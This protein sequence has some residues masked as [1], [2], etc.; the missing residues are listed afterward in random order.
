MA[1]KSVRILAKHG[2]KDNVATTTV[3]PNEIAITSDTHELY[4][5]DELGKLQ[6]VNAGSTDALMDVLVNGMS[7]VQD[8]VATIVIDTGVSDAKD[9]NFNNTFT[10]LDAFNVQDAIDQLSVTAGTPGATG[11][12][13]PVGATGLLGATGPEGATGPI[14]A[15]GLT[16]ASGGTGARGDDGAGI[17]ITGSVDTWSELPSNLT[18]G[19]AGKSFLVRQDGLLYIWDGTQFPNN[20]F[21]IEFRGPRGDAGPQGDL[22]ATG[23]TGPQGNPGPIGATGLDGPMGATGPQGPVG[24]TG[25]QGVQGE[26]G[27][28]SNINPRGFWSAGTNNYVFN[29]YVIHGDQ[30]WIYMSSTPNQIGEPGISPIWGLFVIQGPIG[31]TGPQ[32]NTGGTGPQG[33][34]GSSGLSGPVGASGSQGLQGSV[35]AT[36]TQGPTGPQGERGATGPM[37]QQGATGPAGASGA[38]G[39]DGNSFIILGAYDNETLMR[40]AHPTGMAGDAWA[41]GYAGTTRDIFIWDISANDW[42]DIGNLEGP[43]GASGPQGMQG[44]IGPE[45]PDGPQGIQGATGPEGPAGSAGQQGPAGAPGPMGP[46]GPP[47]EFRLR[48]DWDPEVDD[49]QKQDYVTHLD[50]NAQPGDVAL[51]GWLY[52]NDTMGIIAEPGTNL[53]VWWPFILAGAQGPTGPQGLPGPEGERGPVGPPGQQGQQGPYGP[54]GSTGPAGEAIAV[55]GSFPTYMQMIAT[56]GIPGRAY[57]AEDTGMLY[58][59]RSTGGWPPANAGAF[60]QGQPGPPGPRGNTGLTGDMGAT[61]PQGDRG[62]QGPAGPLGP[63]GERGPEGPRGLEGRSFTIRGRHNSYSELISELPVGEEGWAYSIGMGVGNVDHIFLWDVDDLQWVD[64]GALEGP[65]GASGVPG[66]SGTPGTNGLTGGTGGVGAT[67]PQGQRGADGE[68]GATGPVGERGPMGPP[69]GIGNYITQSFTWASGITAT[70]IREGNWV[71]MGVSSQNISWGTMNALPLGYRPALP[72]FTL[73][74]QSQ[75]SSYRSIVINTNGTTTA[76]GAGT[77]TVTFGM[78]W[79]TLDPFP[80]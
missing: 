57:Y 36:G 51:K 60:I 72:A 78:V 17:S 48:F 46:I 31:A 1:T 74:G 42:V 61:G 8:G 26:V 27:P 64:I 44:N 6:K 76:G 43:T 70:L 45:G 59:Y 29:D 38:N 66:A 71:M 58:V 55:E 11:P 79:Y 68:D 32:G 33:P 37:G 39:T 24:A 53:D 13:G 23:Q 65:Q 20:G 62:L 18:S 67:G 77:G 63:A 40:S 35:G 30:G 2:L 75:G 15:T 28:P 4:V 5:G 16:G 21:G 41:V 34:I 69:G 12:Q 7:V 50:P 25:A 19:D 73:T 80:V 14:G 47:A 49:Y 56:T 9:V 3:L 52:I 10:Q 54:T 22:G